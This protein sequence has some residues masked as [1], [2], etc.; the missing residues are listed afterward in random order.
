M[1]GKNPVNY[2]LLSIVCSALFYGPFTLDLTLVA[3]YL[4]LSFSL[5][6]LL[7]ALTRSKKK[8]QVPTDKTLLLYL[9][10]VVLI[11]L[12]MLWCTTLSEA[13][14]EAGKQL[15]FLIVFFV[16]LSYYK[17][18]PNFFWHSILKISV[19]VFYIT[20]LFAVFQ[21]SGI[22]P[23][24]KE[25]LYSVTGIN[26]HKNLYSSFL[27]LNLFFLMQASRHLD[28]SWRKSGRNAAILSVCLILLLR[29]KAVF[30]GIGFALPLYLILS[31][32]KVRFPFLQKRAG[33]LIT[34]TI[35]VVVVNIFIS[36]V[37]PK[38]V[39]K[40]IAAVRKNQSTYFNPLKLEEERLVLWQK[41][42]H[43]IKQRP[44]LGCGAGNWQIHL[45]D[46]TL[47]GLWRGEDLNYTFQR[48]HNDWLW[49]LSEYGYI[50]FNL[51]L[52]FCILLFLNLLKTLN[53]QSS[54]GDR[55]NIALA[56]SFL[57]G[58]LIISF[59]DFPKERMEHGV[60][61]ALLLAYAYH[62]TQRPEVKPLSITRPIVLVFTGLS[63]FVFYTACLRYKGEFF[64]RQMLNYKLAN[65]PAKVIQSAKSAISF[66]YTLDPTSVPLYWY[67]GNAEIL[68]GNSILSQKDFMKALRLNPYNRNV[69]N[70]LA[71]AYVYNNNVILAKQYYE[72][73]ARISPRFDDPKLNLA[74]LYM[75]AGDYRTADGW[76]KSILHDSQ[77]RDN[78]QKIVDQALKSQPAK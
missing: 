62:I 29:T 60:W 15:C 10:F 13:I 48:P 35:L 28:T 18:S 73:A 57:A 26:G 76:L 49:I 66:A 55:K 58:Y 38:L 27:F 52:I 64:T 61:L 37:L 22:H 45:P 44:V 54:K 43:L 59:F 36:L 14:F 19:T 75:N 46:A 8:I 16:S 71:S 9:L 63:L 5:C 25:E 40:G 2:L 74:V 24:K 70:D 21:L 23:L 6:L 31:G 67:T 39:E 11:G 30:L 50:G 53:K 42:F 51:F 3:R 4:G 17:Q 7:I 20:L 33:L 68:L 78:Y 65:N 72:E 41:T 56:F 69:L 12:S 1:F 47:S 34:A 77:R 32:T